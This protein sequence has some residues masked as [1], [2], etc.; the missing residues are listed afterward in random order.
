G[1]TIEPTLKLPENTDVTL[2]HS[3]NL[4]R[5]SEESMRI[6]AASTQPVFGRLC[7]QLMDIAGRVI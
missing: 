2:A 7:H 5:R 1:Q 3:M 4:R 6:D